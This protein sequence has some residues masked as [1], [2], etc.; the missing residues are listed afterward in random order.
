MQRTDVD[1]VPTF[2]VDT[3][4]PTLAAALV[5][6]QGM[7]DETLTT[8]GWTH[9]LEH[10]VLEGRGSGAL[11]VNGSVGGTVTTFDVHGPVEGVVSHLEEVCRWLAAP[12]LERVDHEATVLRAEADVRGASAAGRALGWRYGARGLGL[13]SYDE[14]G[15]GRATETGL[16]ELATARFHRANAALVLDGPPPASLR[17]PLVQPRDGQPGGGPGPAP[18]PTAVPCDDTLPAG[19]V[20]NAGLVLSGTV[21]R[22]GAGFM[23]AHLLQREL[24]QLLRSESAGA[25]A[26]WSSY[27]HADAGTAVL[28]AGSDVQPSLHP[29]LVDTVIGMLERLSSEGPAEE[30]LRDVVEATVQA[31]GDPYQASGLAMRAAVEHLQGRPVTTPEAHLQAVSDMTTADVAESVT[32][33]RETLLLGVP[34]P[35]TWDDPMPMLRFRPTQ[36]QPSSDSFRSI[37]WPADVS[38]LR[39]DDQHVQMV[40]PRAGEALVVRTDEVVGM[41]AYGD[42]L[43]HVVRSDGYGITIDPR[44]W[45][46]GARAVE[47]LDRVVDEAVHLPHPPVDRP[48]VVPQPPL[49]R[50]WAGLRSRPSGWWGTPTGGLLLVAMVW[51]VSGVVVSLLTGDAGWGVLAAAATTMT[52]FSGWATRHRSQE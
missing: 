9:L 11:H 3:G 44:R 22:D 52:V 40:D 8:S 1:G 13:V 39:V 34:G 36:P 47:L 14:P 19:Y 2:W 26:P 5:F 6:R 12:R 37:D 24:R 17:L 20:E 48:E 42:G 21:A 30:A 50:Y 25:Y 10:L 46:Q 31:M 49:K 4:R 18:L 16:V 51:A 38:R 32:Q 43:R 33:L 15:L 7:V 45:R 35:T 23:A 27:E 29:T 28:L 41:F